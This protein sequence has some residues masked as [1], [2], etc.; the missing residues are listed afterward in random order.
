MEKQI[1]KEVLPHS[2][3]KSS[4]QNNQKKAIASNASAAAFLIENQIGAVDTF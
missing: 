3:E 2:S 4:N 1:C